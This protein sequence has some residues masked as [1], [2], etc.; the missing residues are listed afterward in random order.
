MAVNRN[1]SWS[2]RTLVKTIISLLYKSAFFL[3]KR[4]PLGALFTVVRKF[5]IR[6]FIAEIYYRKGMSKS[7]EGDYTSAIMLFSMALDLDPAHAN[8]YFSRGLARTKRGDHPGALDDYTRVIELYPDVSMVYNNRG[9]VRSK[10]GDRRGALNDFNKAIE[11]D[12][13]N[14]SAYFN[15]GLI[16][17]LGGT[18]ARALA[19]IIQAARLGNDEAQ[20]W[21]ANHG[22]SWQYDC[23]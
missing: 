5:R 20:E 1:K 21:L 23:N 16:K 10:T 8:A 18:D 12:P 9:Q 22:Y 6:S 2:Q 4:L 7:M 17:I 15:R 3:Q 13:A 14:P 19:N 11:L